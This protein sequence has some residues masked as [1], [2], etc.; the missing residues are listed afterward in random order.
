MSL[1]S[2]NNATTNVSLFWGQQGD[3]ELTITRAAS[4]TVSLENAQLTFTIGQSYDVEIQTVPPAD[5]TLTTNTAS[6]LVATFSVDE[7]L[8]ANALGTAGDYTL[9]WQ[10]GIVTASLATATI[11]DTIAIHN[12]FDGDGAIVTPPTNPTYYLTTDTLD[13]AEY[14]DGQYPRWDAANSKFEAVTLTGGGGSLAD[15]DDLVEGATNLYYTDARFDAALG[16]AIAADF[17]ASVQASL[18]AA[19]SAIQSSDLNGY[20]LEPSEGAFV[21]GDKTKL[22]G[23]E[24]NATADQT[25]AEIKAAYESESNTNA[26]TDAEQGKLAGIESG[27]E[28]NNISDAHAAELTGGGETTLHSHAGSGGVTDHGA[29]SGLADDDHAQYALADGTRGNFEPTGAASSAVSAHVGEANPHTQYLQSADLSG[30]QLQPSEGAFVDGDKTKLDG[31]ETSADVT[32]T[33][34]VTAAGAL[35][36]S[37]VTNL[38]AVKAFDPADY[39]MP[40]DIAAFETTTELNAR[41]TANRD[42]ANHTGTQAQSTIT[43]LVSDLAAKLESVAAADITDATATGQAL[44]TA[45]DAA[46]ARAAIGVPKYT[47]VDPRVQEW[48][49]VS[50]STSGQLYTLSSIP[51][52]GR[53]LVQY[54]LDPGIGDDATSGLSIIIESPDIVT[55]TPPTLGGVVFAGE[56]YDAASYYNSGSGFSNWNIGGQ[57]FVLAVNGQIWARRAG[58]YNSALQQTNLSVI[59]Y[60]ENVT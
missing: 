33:A 46:A 31:I 48:A 9:Y 3:L 36:D 14:S 53:V 52:S 54:L 57:G 6:Q 24:P 21:D 50:V 37:E 1:C 4:S 43:D 44:I 26:F 51:S 18:A 23:I 35:M 12:A 16:A 11:Q 22:D 30:Y 20:Q 7:D 40:A 17:S 25:G 39:A 56:T 49:D 59:G 27:A 29:L 8:I 32:D 28:Q 41:D 15:T 58:I 10:V 55:K 47:L 60:W 19:D 2:G 45:T 5:I 38:A 42:R 34:N 13:P